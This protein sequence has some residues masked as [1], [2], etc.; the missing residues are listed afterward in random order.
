MCLGIV[1][2]FFLVALLMAG[3]IFKEGKVNVLP[4]RSVYGKP[5]Y[6]IGGLLVAYLPIGVLVLLVI[7][8]ADRTLVAPGNKDLVLT[9]VLGVFATVLAIC[10]LAA[11]V[12][13]IAFSERDVDEWWKRKPR[14]TPRPR[15]RGRRLREDELEDLEE[16]ER[17]RRRR[18]RDDD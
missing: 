16:E 7:Y 10:L 4:G 17:P 8:A 6:V 3:F 15:P 1:L 5:A 13:G 14:R 9:A 2:F 11:A 18:R 12:I